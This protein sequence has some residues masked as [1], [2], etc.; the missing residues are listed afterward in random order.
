MNHHVLI[1]RE[2][3]VFYGPWDLR[4]TFPSAESVQPETAS[5]NGAPRPRSVLSSGLS[6]FH[7]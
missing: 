7:S 1:A 2:V 6:D 3:V 4:N 5:R